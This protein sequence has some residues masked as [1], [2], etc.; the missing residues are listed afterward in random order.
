MSRHE[1]A[2]QRPKKKSRAGTVFLVLLLL[3]AGA[4]GYLYYSIVKA[5]LELDDP[6]AMA[7]SAPM[8]PEERFRVFPGEQTIQVRLDASDLWNLILDK[9][10]PDFLDTLNRELSGYGLQVSGCGIR[11]EEAGLSLNLELNYNETRL[12]AK[13]PCTLAVSGGTLSLTPAGVKLGVISLP[14]EGLLSSVKLEYPLSLPAL[15]EVTG[16]EFARDALLFTGPLEPDIR[17]LMPQA[18]SLRQIALFREEIR[19]LT[20]ALTTE[21]GFAALLAH[22]EQNPG[23][24]EDL[25]RQLFVLADPSDTEAYRNS[26]LLFHRVFPGIRFEDVAAEQALLNEE[27]T[28][29]VTG[30]EQLFT[31]MVNDYNE[32]NFRLSKGQFLHRGKAFQAAK[33]AGKSFGELFEQLDPESFCPVLVD[34]ADGY[35]RKTSSFYRMA[36]EKQEFTQPVDFN[37]TYILG[38]LFRGGDG[39]PYLMYE[40]EIRTGSN[41]YGRVIALEPLTEEAAASLQQEGKFGVWTNR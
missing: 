5:P 36:D 11:M 31:K 34:A 23:S 3:L 4:V 9:T 10:G 26:R 27:V 28:P 40:R 15:S 25:Y 6:A 16:V 33:Y 39:M 22:L 41:T 2:E 8:A 37:R 1:T 12:A 13:V 29:L 18:D 32:K 19:P 17:A 38:C 7:A 24:L 14:V 35:I 30:L 20:E 21:A